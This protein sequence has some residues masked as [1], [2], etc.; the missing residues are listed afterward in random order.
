MLPLLV[1]STRIALLPQ[2]TVGAN[3]TG[4]SCVRSDEAAKKLEAKRMAEMEAKATARVIWR[5]EARVK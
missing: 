1:A 4:S 5:V 2:V 3:N